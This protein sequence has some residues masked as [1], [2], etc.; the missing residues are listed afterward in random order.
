[1]Q[2]V[3][4][5]DDRPEWMARE[6]N[7]MICFTRCSLYKKCSSR[8]GMDCKRLGGTEIPKERR[9]YGKQSKAEK[10]TKKGHKKA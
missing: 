4:I 10:K 1:M 6:D 5:A 9:R 7:M 2:K 3:I 8:F